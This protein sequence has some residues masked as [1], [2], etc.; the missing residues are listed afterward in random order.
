MQDM[1]PWRLEANAALTQRLKS[2]PTI[3]LGVLFSFLELQLQNYSTHAT[4]SLRTGGKVV[5][6]RRKTA[7]AYASGNVSDGGCRLCRNNCSSSAAYPGRFSGS[8]K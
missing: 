7:Y 3:S 8:C 6:D 4:V 2:L 5:R 1:M